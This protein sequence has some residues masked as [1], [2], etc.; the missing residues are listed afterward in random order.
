[1]FRRQIH[2][3]KYFYKCRIYVYVIHKAPL[4]PVDRKV[5][6]YEVVPLPWSSRE[7]EPFYKTE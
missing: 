4:F 6:V 5:T 1:M 3:M 2:N 7:D